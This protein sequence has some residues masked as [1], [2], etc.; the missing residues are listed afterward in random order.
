MSLVEKTLKP[1]VFAI[2]LAMSAYHVV[3]GQLRLMSPVENQNI[4]LGFSFAILFLTL[5]VTKKNPIARMIYFILA[6]LGVGATAYIHI[7]YMDLVEMAGFLRV[8]DAIVGVMLIALSIEASRSQFG[9]VIPIMTV[10][11]IFYMMFGMYLPGILN[12]GGFSFQRTI[13]SVTTTFNGVYG[14]LLN[15][16]AT[17]IVIFMIFGG[18][19]NGTGG[20]RFFMDLA[21]SVGS[22][23]RAGPALAAVISSAIMGSINGSAVANVATTGAVTIPLM[24]RSGFRPEFAGAVEAAA[25]T[26]GMFLPP[27]MGV[28]AFIMSE[29]TGIPYIDIAIAAFIPGLLY[30]FLIGISV[31]IRANKVGI[32]IL[33]Q[34]DLEPVGRILLRR[35]YYFIPIAVIIYYMVIGYSPMTAGLYAIYWLLAIHF[36]VTALTRPR[37]F[38]QRDFWKELAEGFVDGARNGATVAAILAAVGIMIQAVI[39]TGLAH[40]FL[41]QILVLASSVQVG[42]VMTMFLALFFGMGVP[43]TASYILLAVLVAP[44]L[45][46]LGAPLLAVHLFI[47]Y[48]T[49]VANITP[50]VGSAAIVASRMANGNYMTTCGMAMRLAMVALIMPFMFVWSPALLGDGPWYEILEVTLTAALGLIAIGAFWENYLFCRALAAERMGLLVCGVLLVLPL[51]IYAAAIGAGVFGLILVSQWRRSRARA[52]PTLG[53]VSAN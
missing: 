30:F 14:S 28:G 47:Y 13:A 25:S 12:H 42:L 32:E 7:N 41:F 10:C 51:P 46:K 27:I 38:I 37:R 16:S 2:C 1:V 50:P 15:V 4:H 5:V 24:K 22:R 49:I 8:Q 45:V 26:G 20:G 11:A 52:L 18:L 48:Y 40:R 44:F 17:F 23:F 33:S 35:G 9:W 43:T 29:L 34:E 21:R 3:G 31:A 53:E 19:L 36:A 6:V 39:A